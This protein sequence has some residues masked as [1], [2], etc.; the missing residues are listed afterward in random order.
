[1]RMPPTT[2][3]EYGIAMESW[4]P[5]ADH[6]PRA[7][8][9]LDGVHQEHRQ[10]RGDDKRHEQAG[11][12]LGAGLEALDDEHQGEGG[13]VLKPYAAPSIASHM[14]RNLAASSDQD[15]GDSRT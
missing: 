8:R 1:M 4:V 10:E 6:V 14:S 13:L 9:V 11:D 12:L 7:H 15:S 5:G 3:D 2:A